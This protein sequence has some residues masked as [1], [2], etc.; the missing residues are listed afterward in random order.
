MFDSNYYNKKRN[1]KQKPTKEEYENFKKEVIITGIYFS[2][3]IV[4]FLAF[5][6]PNWDLV[7]DVIENITKRED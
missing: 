7:T 2:I 6:L 3:F 4:V 5:I 1:L